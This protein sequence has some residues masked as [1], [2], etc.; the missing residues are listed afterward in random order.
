[1]DYLEKPLVDFLDLITDLEST[2]KPL[3]PIQIYKYLKKHTNN[4][5]KNKI[6]EAIKTVENYMNPSLF[7]RVW[8]VFIREEIDLPICINLDDDFNL[9]TGDTLAILGRQDIDVNLHFLVKTLGDELE[10]KCELEAEQKHRLE[11]P[12]LPIDLYHNQ[13]MLLLDSLINHNFISKHTHKLSFLVAFG[14]QIDLSNYHPIEW[15]ASSKQSFRELIENFVKP[16]TNAMIK[17]IEILF[18]YKGKPM[19]LNKA[20]K[21]HSADIRN[22]EKIVSM[23][24]KYSD[25]TIS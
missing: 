2:E 18:T 8:Q 24:K 13:R 6:V 19:K 22:I 10:A 20:D 23:V 16:V 17:N 5:E 14:E 4:F 21:N 7:V 9:K 11:I 12:G 1:M 3:I 25:H 15:K